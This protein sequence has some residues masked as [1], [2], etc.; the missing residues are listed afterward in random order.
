MAAVALWSAPA[1]AQLLKLLSP[2]NLTKSH[3]SIDDCGACHQTVREVSNGKCLDCHKTLDK[4][5]RAR[6]GT[7]FARRKQPCVQCHQDHKGGQF[8]SMP[9]NARKFDHGPT[10]FPLDGR[11]QGKDCAGCHK[12]KKTFRGLKSECG[13]CHD[14]KH[15]GKLGANCLGCHSTKANWKPIRGKEDHKL[16]MTGS[17]APLGCVK[18]HAGGEHLRPDNS[19]KGCHKDPHKGNANTCTICHKPTQW[20][21]VTFDH[22]TCAMGL[23]GKHQTVACQSCHEGWQFGGIPDNCKGCHTKRPKHGDLGECGRCH[24]TTSFRKNTFKHSKSKFALTGKHESVDCRH[25]HTGGKFNDLKGKGRGDACL[26]CHTDIPK[27][28]DFGNCSP[29]HDTANALSFDHGGDERPTTM[30]VRAAPA[31][32]AAAVVVERFPLKGSHLAVSCKGCHKGVAKLG[33]AVKD[34]AN[35]HAGD[36]PH[37]G[38]FK[39]RGDA[40]ASCHREQSFTPST[41]TVDGHV[42]DRFPLEDKHAEVACR[43]CHDRGRFVG[44]PT[45]CQGCHLDRHA[46]RLGEE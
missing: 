28:G 30:P 35:C 40:C 1:D 46:G 20:K 8:D 26:D 34:C 12:R 38:Q 33:A 41:M 3:D 37:D 16:T 24:D 43:R 22:D 45:Q 42:P 11:H 9:F 31:G 14:D 25:C 27:H 15:D 17:H 19:C 4:Q 44:V 32:E 5:L 6:K 29:C 10:G 21:E 13:A 7:H 23:T 18:C 36:D 39:D 2:G